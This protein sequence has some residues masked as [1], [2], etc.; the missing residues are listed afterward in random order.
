VECEREAAGRHA[1]W[2]E[3]RGDEKNFR[4]ARKI[5]R[6]GGRSD[7]AEGRHWTLGE[8]QGKMK[9]GFRKKRENWTVEWVF[10]EPS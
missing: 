10:L 7:E 5:C 1:G 2:I 4:P 6:K 9:E 3:K 8:I